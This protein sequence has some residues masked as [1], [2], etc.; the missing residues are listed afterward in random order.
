MVHPVREA[1]NHQRTPPRSGWCGPTLPVSTMTPHR[2]ALG[3]TS[4]RASL[5][6]LA[7]RHIVTTAWDIGQGE[8]MLSVFMLVFLIRIRLLVVREDAT[9]ECVGAG[10]DVR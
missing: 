7:G 1:R 6:P 5:R 9:R 10:R 3:R 8:V 2:D 4:T